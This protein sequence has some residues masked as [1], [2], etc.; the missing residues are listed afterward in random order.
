M[1]RSL[2]LVA[3]SVVIA[4]C[5]GDKQI[6]EV[7]APAD[8]DMIEEVVEFTLDNPEEYVVYDWDDNEVTSQVT[9]DGKLIFQAS[10][11]A[12]GSQKFYISKGERAEYAPIACGNIYPEKL[13]DVAWENDKIGF[14]AYSKDYIRLGST[15]Y[16]Y[17]IFTKRGKEPILPELYYLES[18]PETVRLKK[19]YKETNDKEAYDKVVLK[20]SYH[21]DHGKGMDYYPVGP[22]LGCG[23][24]ALAVKGEVFYPKFYAKQEILDNGPLRFTVRLEYDPVMIAGDEVV[25]ERVVSLDAGSHFNKIRVQYHGLTKPTPVMIGLVLHDEAEVH[26]IT[27]N[28]VAYADPMH[29]SGWQIYNSVIFHAGMRGN[30]LL[31]DDEERAQRAGAYGHIFAGSIYQPETTLTYYM[32]AGWNGWEVPT[33]EDW[34]EIVNREVKRLLPEVERIEL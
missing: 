23:T 30:I 13:H 2:F 33:P 27:G 18:N 8:R 26:Q 25:E 20:T 24:S 5:G 32:G 9:H 3:L 14:R 12:G 21:L 29:S 17:D 4:S 19:L 16:G 28:S 1:I 10:V 15:L 6:L 34:F 11:E 22:T 31:F 7:K